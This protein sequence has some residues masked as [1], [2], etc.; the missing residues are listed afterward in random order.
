MKKIIFQNFKQILSHLHKEKLIHFIKN[1]NMICVKKPSFFEEKL[2]EHQQI[3][4]IKTF[5]KECLKCKKY[6]IC[7]NVF[8]LDSEEILMNINCNINCKTKRVILRKN[9]L[10]NR[11]INN[12][13]LF[14]Y[15]EK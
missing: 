11:E 9:E 13:I 12:K 4:F 5:N 10:L 1:D 15:F 14:F 7:E 8:C 6:I 3:Q 2:S